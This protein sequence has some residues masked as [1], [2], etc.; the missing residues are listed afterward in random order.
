MVRQLSIG[1]CLT[2]T[3]PPGQAVERSADNHDD[4]QEMRSTHARLIDPSVECGS[5]SRTA[6]L[7]RLIVLPTRG[8]YTSIETS[9]TLTQRAAAG[10]RPRDHE[11]P[12]CRHQALSG[13]R[14]LLAPD[15]LQIAAARHATGG[16]Q[17]A[18]GC[19]PAGVQPVPA[20]PSTATSATIRE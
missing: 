4:Q 7:A 3:R 9:S 10:D 12:D 1:A 6:G 20:M 17:H 13:R 2:S 19:R 5:A 15:R 14:R 16:D 18:S 11:G 8:P